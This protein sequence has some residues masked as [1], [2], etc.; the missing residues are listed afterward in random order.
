MSP[1]SQPSDTTISEPLK[2]QLEVLKSELTDANSTI[3][4]M[5]EMTK[6]LKHW[7]ILTWAGAVGAAITAVDLRPYI[8]LTAVIPLLFWSAE[9]HYRLIQRVFI[10]R[11]HRIG[12]YLRTADFRDSFRVGTLIRTRDGKQHDF[13]LL[14]PDFGPSEGVRAKLQVAIYPEI[15]WF[16]L[17]L[18]AISVGLKLAF[19]YGWVALAHSSDLM[20]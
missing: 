15:I 6:N 11:T 12:R 14:H 8:W 5:D 3:R 10:I 7:T 13:P 4:A 18:A 19:V 20:I 2:F 1:G 17:P 16:H 9:V